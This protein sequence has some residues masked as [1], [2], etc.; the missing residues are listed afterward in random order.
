MY[1]LHAILIPTSK[2]TVIRNSK[3]RIIKYSIKDSQ[4]SFFLFGST[5]NELEEKLS[6]VL[7]TKEAIQPFIMFT[8]T[9]LNPKDIMVFFDGIRY[10]FTSFIKAVDTCFQIFMLFNLKYPLASVLVW[11]FIQT[12]FYKI[13][14]SNDKKHPSINMLISSLKY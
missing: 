7:S 2:E 4:N 13:S 10:K 12:F 1:L 3:R 9:I 14:T 5:P 6:K 11:T 8:G